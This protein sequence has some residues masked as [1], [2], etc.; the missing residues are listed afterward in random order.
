MGDFAKRTSHL[1]LA[2][3]R[4]NYCRG[5]LREGF[6]DS[7]PIGQF[8]DWIK[9]AQAAHLKEPNAMTL[10]TVSADGRPS[11]RIVLLK[12]VSDL[13][14]VFYTNY[15]S[16]K[17]QELETNPFCALTFYWAELERQV[18]V[19]G[20]ATHVSRAESERYFRSRPKGSRLGAIVSEQSGIMT[21]R[22]DLERRLAE[23]EQRYS[24]TDDVPL[25]ENWGGYRVI[26]ESIEFWQGRPNRL[27]DRLR[28]RKGDLGNWIIERLSP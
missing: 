21:G 16:R 28:Y 25:P 10:S 18:R 7:D 24:G 20:R 22:A 17:G 14:F 15:G 9:H 5:E 3:L 6:C 12:E 8:E 2:D 27:H 19:E 4:E 26:P 13:G 1:S 23:L 11:G